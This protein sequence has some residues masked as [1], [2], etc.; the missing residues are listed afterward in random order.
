MYMIIIIII[1]R[2]MNDGFN[3]HALSCEPTNQFYKYMY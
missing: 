1:I 2:Y 3:I